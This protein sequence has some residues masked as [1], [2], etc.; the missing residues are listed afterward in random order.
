MNRRSV[1]RLMMRERDWSDV[2]KEMRIRKRGLA[3][4]GAPRLVPPTASGAGGASGPTCSFFSSSS[5]LLKGG[6]PLLPPQPGPFVGL[7]P[8]RCTTG[9]NRS[10]SSQS[11]QCLRQVPDPGG[12]LTL[13]IYQ[14]LPILQGHL[15]AHLL[16]APL[17]NLHDP[18]PQCVLL[19]ASH[20]LLQ[21]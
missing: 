8:M 9:V 17:P 20:F 14:I 4:E 12:T 15:E 21:P 18:S 19:P 6:F 10:E 1:K 3:S 16:W 11:V 7:R 2:L 13:F 5:A